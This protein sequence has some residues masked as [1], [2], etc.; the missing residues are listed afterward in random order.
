VEV[1]GWLWVSFF[2]IGPALIAIEMFVLPR[3]NPLP[4]R[5]AAISSAVC[6]VIG[7][8]F[9][10]LVGMEAG[11]KYA[12]KYET[13]FLIEKGLT[14]DQVLVFALFL[15]AFAPPASIGKRLVY[16][17]LLFGLFMRVPFIVLGSMLGETQSWA[18]AIAVSASFFAGTVLLVRTRHHEP[19]PRHGW[20]VRR[21]ALDDRIVPE[22]RGN[23][24]WVRSAAGRRELTL[25]GV[26]LGALL[27]ADLF[28]AGAVPLGFSYAKPGI[29]VFAS[30]VFAL[31]GFRSMFYVVANLEFD[32]GRLKVGLAVVFALVGLDVLVHPVWSEHKPSWFLPLVAFV[33]IAI[34]VAAAFRGVRHGPPAGFGSG[35]AH[36]SS[37][38]RSA[39]GSTGPADG[40]VAD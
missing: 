9:G 5:T 10:S 25:A 17:S 1:S 4:L 32:V 2:I 16:W 23:K 15:H 6:F 19:D 33:A 38:E 28:F 20:F 12:I 37:D 18:V 35:I 40:A 36:G 13:G 30:S 26:L 21:L 24:L 27:T 3:G 7:F 8:S 22:Y 29:L 39:A 34:P 31:L 11:E 14:V